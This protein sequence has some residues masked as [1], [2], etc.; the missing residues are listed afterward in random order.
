MGN[1]KKNF[2][3]HSR[4]VRPPCLLAIWFDIIGSIFV[5][6]LDP[7]W[8]DQ[9][10]QIRHFRFYRNYFFLWPPDHRGHRQLAKICAL[11]G[12]IFRKNFDPIGWPVDL[13]SPK[14]VKSVLVCPPETATPTP[15]GPSFFYSNLYG[16]HDGQW[17]SYH[18]L[19]GLAV[20]IV[21]SFWQKWKKS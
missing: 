7:I 4:F 15:P 19:Y 5:Q 12:S 6:N 9:I 18:Y 10:G 20:V 13:L 14:L 3:G 11:M 21:K 2:Y 1:I 8:F 16:Q 17:P